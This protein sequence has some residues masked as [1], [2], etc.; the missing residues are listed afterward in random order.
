MAG[1]ILI[2][3]DEEFVRKVT[4]E[5]LRASGFRV[6]TAADAGDAMAIF[7]AHQMEIELVLTDMVMPGRSG[8]L[9][10]KDLQNLK[11]ELRIIV[12][13]GYGESDMDGGLPGSDS[14]YYLPKPYSAETLILKVQ[15]VIERMH[16]CLAL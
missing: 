3:E 8:K 7:R 12:T 9:L 4:C 5:V 11:P 13:S 14:I 6:F 16:Q 2:V 1:S 15:G 10:A